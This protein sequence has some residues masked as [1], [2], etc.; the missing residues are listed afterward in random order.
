[1]LI[2]GSTVSGERGETGRLKGDNF[3]GVIIFLFDRVKG[4]NGLS[5]S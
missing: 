4:R 2:Q 1:M 3:H 5:A